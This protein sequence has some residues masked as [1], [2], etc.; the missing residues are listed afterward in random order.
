M[1]LFQPILNIGSHNDRTDFSAVKLIHFHTVAAASWLLGNYQCL[2]EKRNVESGPQFHLQ[3]FFVPQSSAAH[4]SWAELSCISWEQVWIIRLWW[5]WVFSLSP[6]HI[7]RC[8][9][10]LG[11]Y[12]KGDNRI[13]NLVVKMTTHGLSRWYGILVPLVLIIIIAL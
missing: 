7:F 2:C 1:W 8:H 4:F 10:I 5:K 11:S 13:W 9:S 3:T 12:H 6:W